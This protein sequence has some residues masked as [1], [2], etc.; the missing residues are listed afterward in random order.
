MLSSFFLFPFFLIL[1]FH[2]FSFAA[3]ALFSNRPS[4]LWRVILHFFRCLFVLFASVRGHVYVIYISIAQ[5]NGITISRDTLYAV[6]APAKMSPFCNQL[7]FFHQLTSCDAIT[8]P[9]KLS[10]MSTF[11]NEHWIIHTKQFNFAMVSFIIKKK[12]KRAC[13]R[14]FSKAIQNN[15]NDSGNKTPNLTI[16]QPF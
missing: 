11:Q 10:N 4:I 13:C 7:N 16:W 6:A 14:T 9:I 8:E 5:S 1:H 12:K 2:P 15:Y 3:V